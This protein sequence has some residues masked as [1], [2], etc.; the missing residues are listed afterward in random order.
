MGPATRRAVQSEKCLVGANI[1]KSA[2]ESH[3]AAMRILAEELR[4][5]SSVIGGMPEYRLSLCL[6]FLRR[7][8][9]RL[10]RGVFE[11][12]ITEEDDTPMSSRASIAG[13]EGTAVPNPANFTHAT[14]ESRFIDDIPR[15]PDELQGALVLTSV[16]KGR[17]VSVDPS[18]ALK[19]PGVTGFYTAKVRIPS[20]RRVACLSGGVSPAVS[21]RF[22]FL[23][24]SLSL[25]SLCCVGDHSGHSWA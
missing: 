14:G 2:G 17:I 11:E 8:L 25:C 20:P 23:T 21:L 10:K 12:R 6:S 19:L 7:S 9:D 16:P 5:P 1:V 22:A 18:A 15:L 4:L 3:G 24:F 13:H